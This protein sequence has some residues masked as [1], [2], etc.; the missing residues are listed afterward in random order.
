[1][2][3]RVIVVCSDQHCGSTLGLM[4]PEGVTIADGAHVSPSEP[5]R[6]LWRQHLNFVDDAERVVKQWRE[7]GATAHYVNLGDLTDGDHHHTHQIIGRDQG[8]HI[9]AARNVLRDGFLGLS[10]DS[11]HFVM[12]TPSHVG[13]AGGN[14]KSVASG[15]EDE[16][17][18]VVRCPWNGDTTLWPWLYMDIGAY[19]FD[20]R[21]HGRT[22][23]REHTRKSYQAIYSYDIHGSH[24]NE[25]RRPP[26]VAVRAHKHKMMD[27]GPDHRGITR[28][29]NT[30]CWQF[31]SE[32]VQSRAIES[33]PDFGG[34]IFVVTDD[35]RG[36]YD[37]WARPYMYNAELGEVEQEVW[38]P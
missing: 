16:G 33:R 8:S 27:S 6:W 31:S 5:V 26:D 20:F 15:L 17:Y 32:W 11:L 22:G 23:M 21:H 9:A 4:T 24:L 14:E 34:W 36:P 12:G 18:P 7:R 29:V 37:L 1:M 30:G 2:A 35:M 10:F 25:G 38:R 13:R 3:P 19:R 28:T